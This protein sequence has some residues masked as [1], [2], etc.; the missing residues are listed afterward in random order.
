[1]PAPAQAP[2]LHWMVFSPLCTE[3]E[4]RSAR[5]GEGTSTPGYLALNPKRRVPALTD[6]SGAAGGA[7]DLL[8]E[9]VAILIF[10]TRSHPDAKLLPADPAREARCLEWLSWLSVDLHGIGYG[11]LWRAHRFVDDPTLHPTIV[12]KGRG[13]CPP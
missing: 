11:P 7:P 1:M 2:T 3:T 8:T 13:T 9:A 5:N 12:A 10:L 6:V 4:V